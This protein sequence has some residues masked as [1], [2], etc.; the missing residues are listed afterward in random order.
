[1]LTS[2]AAVLLV[3]FAFGNGGINGQLTATCNVL[4]AT[5]QS[6]S[7]GVLTL[8]QNGN[9]VTITGTLRGLTDGQ[10]GF[11]VHEKGDLGNA[12]NNAGAH[13]NPTHMD[14]G[15][16]TDQ[17]R[18]VGDLG[19][20]ASFGGIANVNIQDRVI[21]LSG[22]HSIIGLAIVVHQGVDDLGRGNSPL[23]KTTGNAGARAACGV[24]SQSPPRNRA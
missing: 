19:N 10:H 15:A 22:P 14:H 4:N 7:I 6:N 11:H 24:I 1:M 3:L 8:V 9:T 5:Q 20:I 2:F 13:F 12:C 18:H 16:P 21:Q 23:S 17:D